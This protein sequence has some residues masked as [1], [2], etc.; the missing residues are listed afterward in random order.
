MHILVINPPNTPYTPKG[1]LIEP[2]DSLLISTIIRNAGFNVTLKDLDLE[3]SLTIRSLNNY[4]L[5]VMV[6]DYHIPLHNETTLTNIKNIIAKA[7]LSNIPTLMCGKYATYASDDELL[8]LGANVYIKHDIEPLILPLIEIYRD[9]KSYDHVCDIPGLSINVNGK[10]IHTD[11]VSKS[12]PRTDYSLDKLPIPDRSLVNVNDYIDV[13]TMLSSRG[14]HQHC[15]FCHVP[16]FWGRW[17]YRSVENTLLEI[18]HI[19]KTTGTTKILFLDDN[20]VV[21]RNRML[22]ICAGLKQLNL[23]ITLGCLASVDRVDTVLMEKMYNSGFRWLHFGVETGESSHFITIK[24]RIELEQI[25]SAFNTANSIGFRTRASV[26]LDL[27]GANKYTIDETGKL[28]LKLSPDEI[29][30]HFLAIRMGS[31]YFD[32]N[33]ADGSSQYIHHNTP[34]TFVSDM[35]KNMI[36]THTSNLIA[37]CSL[38]GYLHID[39]MNVFDDMNDLKRKSPELKLVGQCPIRYGLD[40]KL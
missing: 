4:D 34:G 18:E 6:H 39:S 2:I 29:R 27:P 16:G 28:L 35:K 13:R 24:K 32:E 33:L 23:P 19:Y 1:I 12:T 36:L 20:A 8:D 37:K 9:Y 14:C 5:L 11:G 25:T 21:N 17:R 30:L 3:Q 22:D 40:W 15:T 26:I 38:N 31:T 10:L 7:K